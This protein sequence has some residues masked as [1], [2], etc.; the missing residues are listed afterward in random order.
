MFGSC[1]HDP[2]GF[3]PL[4]GNCQFIEVFLDHEVP[5]FEVADFLCPGSVGIHQI[6]KNLVTEAQPFL[7]IRKPE[8]D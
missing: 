7:R 1:N 5:D 8:Q 3:V 2:A 4:S 6:Q